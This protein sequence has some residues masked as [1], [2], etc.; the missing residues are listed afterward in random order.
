M[1]AKK[2]T[3]LTILI[4]WIKKKQTISQFQ[5][6]NS[7]KIHHFTASLSVYFDLTLVVHMSKATTHS[8]THTHTQPT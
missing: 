3:Y 4:F 6:L 5:Q 2:K 1:K 7:A 8:H